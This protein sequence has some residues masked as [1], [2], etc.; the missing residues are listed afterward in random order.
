MSDI[1]APFYLFMTSP[2]L[3]NVNS[4]VVVV[5]VVVVVVIAAVT[6]VIILPDS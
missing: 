3:V 1:L 2:S 5:V 6:V 4:I